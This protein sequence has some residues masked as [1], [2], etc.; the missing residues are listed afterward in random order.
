[1]SFALEGMASDTTDLIPLLKN[2]GEELGRLEG[3]FNELGITIGATDLEKITEVGNKFDELTATF[4]ATSKQLIAEYSEQLIIGIE[5]VLVFAQK[6][7]E[8]FNVVTTGLGN[9]LAIA[10]AA[11]TDFVNGTDTLDAVI[12]ERA[13]MS[14]RAVGK[15]FGTVPEAKEAGKEA[16]LAAAEGLDEAFEEAEA[17]REERR[18]ERQTNKDKEDEE[19]NA[20]E[21]ERITDRFL[22]ETELLE[23]KY[24]EE[25][26]IL[27]RLIVD[28]QERK[29][30][31][32]ALEAEFEANKSAIR[33]EAEE[34][35]QKAR[36]KKAK[37]T[38]K[39]KK[40]QEKA[41]KEETKTK[42][43]AADDAMA[44]TGMLFEDNKAV[45]AG[46]IVAKTATNVV[47]SVKNSGGVPWGLPAGAAAAAMGIAQLAALKGASKGGGSISAGGSGTPP[48]QS[49]NLGL[50]PEDTSTLE[51]DS[52]TTSGGATNTS[53]IVVRFEA[54]EGDE[55]LNV[56][57][58]GLNEKNRRGG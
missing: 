16:G 38:E 14:E 19:R 15:L 28:E 35:E 57:A 55:L 36:E 42:K 23:K 1:M 20:A 21:I 18:K 10:Q 27:D 13:A 53:E 9:L 45:E 30:A 56:I 31:L 11:T 29:E 33:L 40:E 52:D 2:G 17:R 39:E 50:N 5:A 12:A 49:S 46:M 22:T 47:E 34:K 32:L 7:T 8:T 43:Q 4:G 6:T 41:A 24:L 48:I 37:A 3:R 51:I 26:E 25:K 58:N 54:N 44:L